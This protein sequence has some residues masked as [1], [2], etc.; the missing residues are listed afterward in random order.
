[1]PDDTFPVSYFPIP[2]QRQFEH[3]AAQILSLRDQPLEVVT[4][5]HLARATPD[6]IEQRSR[7]WIGHDA[8]LRLFGGKLSVDRIGAALGIKRR[9]AGERS[10]TSSS[11]TTRS[12]SPSLPRSCPSSGASSG[13]K[14]PRR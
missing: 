5:V 1:M 14:V 12:S 13:G 4:M 11:S 9:M 10:R 7:Y 6:G 2:T 8:K 3:N